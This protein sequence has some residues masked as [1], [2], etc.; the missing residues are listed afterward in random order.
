M[1]AGRPMSPAVGFMH[2][3]LGNL[4]LEWNRLDE[5]EVQLRQALYWAER[6]G[7]HKMLYYSREG[8]ARLLAAAGDWPSALM[9]TS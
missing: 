4:L 7:D 6:S 3:G 2:V 1:L 9:M 5:A 8:L